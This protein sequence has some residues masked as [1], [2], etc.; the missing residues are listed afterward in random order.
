[1]IPTQCKVYI[2]MQATYLGFARAKTFITEQLD[3]T[4]RQNTEN[5]SIT[6]ATVPNFEPVSSPLGYAGEQIMINGFAYHS[7][8]GGA[9]VY[10]PLSNKLGPS[11]TTAVQGWDNSMNSN[12]LNVGNGGEIESASNYT[13]S[14]Q[15]LGKAR[16]QHFQCNY[17]E[18]N[19]ENPKNLST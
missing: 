4:A 12:P 9:V 19:M 6:N 8:A 7:G 15:A 14:L 2:T 3:E 11:I 1:M 10:A 13:A 5:V 16:A 18:V 17:V